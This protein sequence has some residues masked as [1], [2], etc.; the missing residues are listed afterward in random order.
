MAKKRFVFNDETIINSYGFKIL[1]AGISLERFLSNP[2]MLDGHWNDTHNVIGNWENVVKNGTLLEG[3]SNFDLEDD[4]AKKLAGKVERGFIKGCSMGVTFDREKMKQQPDGTWVLSECELFEV[5]LVAIPSNRS[6]VKLFSFEGVE[7]KE[8]EIKLAI[9]ELSE[10]PNFN[11][12]NKEQTMEK[13]TLSVKSLM[14]LGLEDQP[15]DGKMLDA[16]IAE[17]AGKHDAEKLAH[18][19]TKKLFKAGET[20]RA[21]A[22]VSEAKLAGK[23]TAAEEEQF[24]KDATEN[25]ALTARL[26]A[27]LP[28]KQNLNANNTGQGG[29]GDP[30][31]M[32]EFEKLSAEA[33]LAFKTENPDGYKALFR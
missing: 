25:Y 12:N 23:I 20:E 3:D 22:L 8:D 24:V 9:S 6:C 15:T 16:K 18:E 32:D 2:I 11:V 28:A 10:K 13:V 27:K 1:N 29:T 21:K 31:N 14:T 19:D 33:K 4:V 5:S 26:L 30:K 17:L 7:M